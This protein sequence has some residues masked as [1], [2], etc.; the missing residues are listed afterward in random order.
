MNDGWE[1]VRAH[2]GACH[3]HAVVRQQRGKAAFW[4]ATID[5]MQSQHGLWRFDAPTRTAIVDYL[6]TTFAVEADDVRVRR[7]PLVLRE[8]P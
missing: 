1:T 6:S 7:L 5:R 2:C 3:S 8:N 4:Q